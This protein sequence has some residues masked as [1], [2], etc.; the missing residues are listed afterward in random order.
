MGLIE[1]ERQ[2]TATSTAV[3]VANAI[4]TKFEFMRHTSCTLSSRGLGTGEGMRH[5]S[6]S[7]SKPDGPEVGLTRRVSSIAAV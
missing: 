4:L 3:N 6:N 1:F 2:K 7:T 5:L